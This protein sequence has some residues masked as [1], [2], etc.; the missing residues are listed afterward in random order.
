VL[1]T[2]GKPSVRRGARALF[3]S[4]WTYGG[5][6]IEFQSFSM[7]I[8]IKKQLLQTFCLWQLHTGTLV[9]MKRPSAQS[10]EPMYFFGIYAI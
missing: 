2:N 6:V 10:I 1:G 4:V 8:K 5:K 7:N 9:P 3:Y